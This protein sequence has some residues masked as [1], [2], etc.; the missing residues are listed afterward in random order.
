M[1][2]FIYI[3]RQSVVIGDILMLSN[4]TISDNSPHGMHLT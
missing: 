4:V 3:T 2:T 1:V